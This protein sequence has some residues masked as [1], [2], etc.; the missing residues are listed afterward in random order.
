MSAAVSRKAEFGLGVAAGLTALTVGL[1]CLDKRTAI[2]DQSENI[3]VQEESGVK[4]SSLNCFCE[5]SKSSVSKRSIDERKQTYILAGDIGGTNSRFALYRQGDEQKKPIFVQIYSNK[6]ALR[7]KTESSIIRR[8]LDA[9]VGKDAP[10]Y[11]HETL[12]PFLEKCLDKVEEWK[13]LGKEEVLSQIQVVACLATAGP[14][15]MQ[16]DVFM[17]NL[18]KKGG[19]I[20]GNEIE[21]CQ[22]EL[23]ALVVRCKQ[24][25]DFVGQGYGMLDLDFSNEKE[26]IEL[27]PGSKAKMNDLAPKCCVGAGTGLGECFLTKSSLATEKGYECYPSEGGH[28]DFVPRG[29][30]EVELLD[31]LK[32]KIEREDHIISDR[33]SVERVVSG[34]GLANVYEFLAQKF[35]ERVDKKVHEEFLNAGDQQGRVVGVNS[36]TEGSLAQQAVQIMCA[37][38]GSEVG[39]AALKFLP[40]GGMFVT[41]GLIPKII[42]TNIGMIQG[43][44]SPFMK[45][46]LDKGRFEKEVRSIPLF[47]VMTEDVGLRGARV[48]AEREYKAMKK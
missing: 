48:I 12:Q 7:N 20:D 33:I 22:D 43:E 15:T 3:I 29:P 2:C 40:R 46:Y 8:I 41:G 26:V 17:V 21:Q 47:A 42:D 38:Y 13:E 24:I 19:D 32:K 23:I 27:L 16:N 39:N 35:P 28:A 36:G 25:N 31:Y 10:K 45:A 6:E 11:H 9:L 30:L 34:R 37:A 14:V 4:T 5:Q 1:A 18:G 44:N